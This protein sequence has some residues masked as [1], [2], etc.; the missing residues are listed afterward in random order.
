MAF[1]SLGTGLGGRA[2]DSREKSPLTRS[3]VKAIKSKLA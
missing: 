1:E 2:G 3:G